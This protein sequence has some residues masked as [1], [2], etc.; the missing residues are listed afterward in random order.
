MFILDMVF[1][2]FFQAF[3]TQR[4]KIQHASLQNAAAASAAKQRGDIRAAGTLERQGENMKIDI[5]EFAHK[6]DEIRLF[7]QGVV[8]YRHDGTKSWYQLAMA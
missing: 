7:N 5:A 6:L 8:K 3:V 4:I 2:G 1:G